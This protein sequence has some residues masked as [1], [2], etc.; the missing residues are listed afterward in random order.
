LE[1][2]ARNIRI[3][4][5]PLPKGRGIPFGASSFGGENTPSRFSGTG[6]RA[7]EIELLLKKERNFEYE[8]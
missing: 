4:E 7:A 5:L 3:N 6:M 8:L 2:F 1:K